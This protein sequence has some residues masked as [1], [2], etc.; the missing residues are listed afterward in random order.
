MV[1]SLKCVVALPTGI[2][3]LPHRLWNLTTFT[4]SHICSTVDLWC[5]SLMFPYFTCFW[6]IV[7]NTGLPEKVKILVAACLFLIVHSYFGPSM[8]SCYIEIVLLDPYF[9]DQTRSLGDVYRT[10]HPAHPQTVL[11]HSSDEAGSTAGHEVRPIVVSWGECGPRIAGLAG[12]CSCHYAAAGIFRE[13]K[14]NGYFMGTDLHI[15][16]WE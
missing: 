10:E 3:H 16:A 15:S 2:V 11:W 6:C 9:P 5:S 7:L 1:I 4:V 12:K 14:S 8:T 13:K